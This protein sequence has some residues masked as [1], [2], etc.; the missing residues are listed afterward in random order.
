MQK[1]QPPKRALQFLRWFCREDFLG[2]IEGDLL[3]LYSLRSE[4]VNPAK[5]RQQFWWDVLRSFRPVNFKQFGFTLFSSG[6]Y[7]NYLITSIRNFGRH[8]SSFLINLTGLSTGLACTLLILL[9]VEDE[10]RF[11]T[12]YPQAGQMYKVLGRFAYS[13]NVEI[14]EGVPGPLADL[15]KEDY[16]EIEFSTVSTWNESHL[17]GYGDK[18]INATG[19]FGGED[20]FAVFQRPAIEGSLHNALEEPNTIAISRSLADRLF[21]HESALGHD[22]RFNL[23]DSY[24]VTAVFED[25]PVNSTIKVDWVSRIDGYFYKNNGWAKEWGNYG[26]RAFVRL[27]SGAD[28]ADVSNKIKDIPLRKVAD[29]T[30]TFFLYPFTDY[31][32]NG[33]F[34]NGEVAGGRIEYVRLFGIIAGFI[35][36]IA[37]INFMNLSTARATR[38]A[39][40]IGIRKAIGAKR[41][42]LISQFFCES[43]LIAAFSLVVGLVLVLLVLPYF[44]EITGKVIQ[45]RFNEPR[46]YIYLTSMIVLTG[47][48][49]GSYPAFYLASFKVVKVLK[50]VVRGSAAEIFARKGLVIFQFSLSIT[51]IIA[52][53]VI[54]E[55]VQYINRK[56]LGYNKENLIYFS[57]D[58]EF[59][60]HSEAFSNE[61]RQIRGVVSV[62]GSNHKLLGSASSTPHIQWEGKNDAQLVNFE[63]IRT[64]YDFVKT[65]GLT[66]IDGRD[67]SK[68]FAT[69]SAKLIINEAAAKVMHLQEPVGTKVK[70][71]GL[72]WEIIGVAKDFHFAS[73]HH[74]I[75]PVIITLQ[76]GI[77]WTYW[78]RL[79]G[80]DLAGTLAEIDE[81]YKKVNPKYPFEYH[82]QDERLGMLYAAEQRIGTLSTYFA[83]FAILISALGLL[84]LAAYMTEKR[85]K[86]VG[87]RKIMGASVGQLVVL[88]TRD[89]TALVLIAICLAIPVSWYAMS[90]WLTSFEFKISLSI[91]YFIS[92]GL[93]AL[94]I[95]WATVGVQSYRAASANPSKS[96]KNNE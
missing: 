74:A 2:E 35:L 68:D 88:L 51:L 48:L 10:L 23:E 3:E 67:F 81:L 89:F 13:D 91:W 32:L 80:N 40:E 93:A 29:S 52:T 42:Q 30:S 44:N 36:I 82:F 62:S 79:D 37:C 18:N 92:A 12:F 4:T 54:Y 41:S 31:Y 20:F 43:F 38:R 34:E 49:A 58:Q 75:S 14:G 7:K 6:M 39:K 24:K 86:E 25:F 19:R 66:I 63:T 27:R 55:Q 22:I 21:D 26:P 56:N 47:F 78:I 46:I 96:L 9:W 60:K 59:L 87:I 76:P 83:V 72:E 70:M 33:T 50:G 5:A 65:L 45:L 64:N 69:D 17:I 95:A 8:K 15:L 1:L 94:A 84:G 28:P 71:W 85:I 90:S 73:I 61:V 77:S 11:D 53:A 57:A 16:P